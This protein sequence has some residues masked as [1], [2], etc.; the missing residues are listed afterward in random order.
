VIY[1]DPVMDPSSIRVLLN[2]NDRTS[3]FHVRPGELELVSIPLDLGQH[4][5]TIR[6]TNK[7]GESSVQEFHIQH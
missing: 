1:Y 7:D 4:A 3:L 5:L 6:A 2:E